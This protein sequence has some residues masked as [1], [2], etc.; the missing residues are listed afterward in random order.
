MPFLK[1]SIWPIRITVWYYTRTFPPGDAQV[2]IRHESLSA[3]RVFRS[4][5]P[6]RPIGLPELLSGRLPL[7]QRLLRDIVTPA[8]H[9][10][11]YGDRGVGKTSIAKVLAVLAQDEDLSNGRRSIVVSCDS[12]DT[13][14]SIW[15]K[16]FQEVLL[17]ERQLGFDGYEQ[18][19]IVG[20]WDANDTIS[21]PNDV[22]LLLG[23]LPNPSTVIID[24]FDRIHAGGDASRLMTDTIK[25]FSDTDTPCSLVLVGVGQSIEQLITA[26]ESISRNIDYVPVYP[27][28]PSEL[29]EIVRKGMHNAGLSLEH[30]LDSRIAHLSQGYPHYTHLLAQSA[31]LQAIERKSDVVTLGDLDLA[32]PASI[33][34]TTG[35]IRV[36][37][38]RATDS[39]QPNNLFKEVLLACALA[40]KDVRGRFASADVHEPLKKIMHPR[41]VARSSYQRH[42]SLFCEPEHGSVLIKTG[43]RKNYRWHFANPQLIPFVRLQGIKEG[44]I[45]S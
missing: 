40:D 8:Q 2:T 23:R 42:L 45:T 32:I 30:G 37:Y 24:E 22:R 10:L 15:R 34:N 11:L 13:Y 31:G 25:L 14:G 43:R 12:N 20:R 16:V 5:T 33:E 6:T 18:R 38:H 7:L 26:H 44:M 21:V 4:F 36:E 35:G 17:M 9:V 41:A 28:E 29:A 1:H 27:L 3:V 19:S 39:T